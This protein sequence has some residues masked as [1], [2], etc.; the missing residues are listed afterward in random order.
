MRRIFWRTLVLMSGVLA[1]AAQTNRPADVSR[2]KSELIG[3]TMGGREQCWKFR[4]A[5]QIKELV[6]L[7]QTDAAQKRVY[8]VALQLQAPEGAGKY[9][10]DARITYARTGEAW[11]IQSVG[12][13][14]LKKMP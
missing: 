4:S 12:L 8:T 6:I 2:L 13:L 5:D 3:W 11:K 9:A 14:R 7:D 1:V 10:A